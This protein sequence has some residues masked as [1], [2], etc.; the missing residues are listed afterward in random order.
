MI[1]GQKHR[2]YALSFPYKKV[3]SVAKKPRLSH[4]AKIGVNT[5][6]VNRHKHTK[7]VKKIRHK[8]KKK[9]VGIF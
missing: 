4:R 9:N 6:G 7:T 2:K 3:I 5:P 8:N 1:S